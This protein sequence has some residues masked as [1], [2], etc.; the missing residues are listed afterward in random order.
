[1]K[2]SGISVGALMLVMVWAVAQNPLH[3]RGKDDA[4]G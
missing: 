4:G 1:M 2:T 3:S